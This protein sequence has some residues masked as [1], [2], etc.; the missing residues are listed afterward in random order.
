MALKKIAPAK[1]NQPPIAS[2]RK[3]RMAKKAATVRIRIF[4]SVLIWA[5]Y[6]LQFHLCS[7]SYGVSCWRYVTTGLL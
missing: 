1:L 2:D 5:D 3:A 4:G 6:G 7:E